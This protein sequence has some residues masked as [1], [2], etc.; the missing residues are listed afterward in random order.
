MIRQARVAD[1]PAFYELGQRLLS[2]TPYSKFP[3]DRQSAMHAYGQCISSA[4]GFAMVAESDGKLTGVL[5]GVADRLWW[6][7]KRY[8]SDLIF[9]SEDGRSG[10]AL[11]RA[12]IKWAESVPGV[13]D[14][15]MAQSS[16]INIEKT[17]ALYRRCG[18]QRVGNLWTKA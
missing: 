16:G 7:N 6:S 1:W 8:A 9:Y 13:V 3:V 4:L 10:L 5:L 2:R 12:F 17:A 14:I 18:F 15:T 11:M